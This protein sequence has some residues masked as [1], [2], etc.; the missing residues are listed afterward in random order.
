MHR[1]VHGVHLGSR[2]KWTL[3]RNRVHRLH[4]ELASGEVGIAV[5]LKAG[6][7]GAGRKA[8]V[9]ERAWSNAVSR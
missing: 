3:G 5:V 9:S 8:I 2:R 6:V 7:A 1:R 4:A